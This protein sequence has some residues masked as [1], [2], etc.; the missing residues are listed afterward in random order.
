MSPKGRTV[1]DLI[2]ERLASYRA[3]VGVHG[4]PSCDVHFSDVITGRGAKNDPL[5][6]VTALTFLTTLSRRG[7]VPWRNAVGGRVALTGSSGEM[8]VISYYNSRNPVPRRDP[9]VS[10]I[11]IAVRA[12][13]TWT[14]SVGASLRTEQHSAVCQISADSLVTV[15]PACQ[16][17][18][19][20]ASDGRLTVLTTFHFRHCKWRQFFRQ[21][22]LCS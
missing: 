20:D 13:C 10:S 7:Q 17:E 5:K 1:S 9:R 14:A 15:W 22:T 12:R 18:W 21:S 8:L 11:T 6:G 16:C 19:H 2:I 4:C 3:R